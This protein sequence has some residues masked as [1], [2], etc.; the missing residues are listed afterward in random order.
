MDTENKSFEG[1]VRQAFA[2]AEMVPGERV[3]SGLELFLDEPALAAR[4]TS[5]YKWL[6]AACLLLAAFSAGLNIYLLKQ[7]GDAAER[8]LVAKG[9]KVDPGQAPP[10]LPAIGDTEPNAVIVQSEPVG[11]ERSRE[12]TEENRL[13]TL[14]EENR[15]RRTL[16]LG[17]TKAE[18]ENSEFR[19]QNPEFQTPSIRYATSSIQY[20]ASSIQD[21]TRSIENPSAEQIT[22]S[23]EQP[24]AHPKEEKKKSKDRHFSENSRLFASLG[25]GAGSF[26]PQPSLSTPAASPA[27]GGLNSGSSPSLSSG[28]SY[29]AGFS[30]GTKVSDRFVLTGGVS[31]LNQSTS[32]TSQVAQES[33]VS[34]FYRASSLADATVDKTASL[35]QTNPYDV[36]STLEYISVPLQA[37]YLIVDRRFGWQMNGGLSTDFFLRNTL[38]SDASGFLKSSQGS[39]SESPYTGVGFSGL[40]N[41]ELSYRFGD[42]YRLSLNPGMRY[43]LNSLYKS[44]VGLTSQ[45]LTLDVGLR[46]RYLF[47]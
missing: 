23:S 20:P 12:T 44:S 36:N 27:V 28:S 18:I 29:S 9:D 15:P 34:G 14:M 3:W 7:N 25:F 30:I 42:R 35:V 22:T 40:L 11:G 24:T 26:N 45:P 6:A 4:K 37:G 46:L 1:Q 8:A 43:S 38:N 47:K 31:Y 2:G 39:G 21:P 33:A 17:L 41:T 16:R 10:D 32:F 13:V 5:F 19:I